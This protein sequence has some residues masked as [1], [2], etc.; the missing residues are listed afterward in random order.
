MAGVPELG[1]RAEDVGLG[2]HEHVL[3]ERIGFE[4]GAARIVFLEAQA[5][6]WRAAR[7]LFSA[8]ISAR[9][10]CDATLLED[11][12]L[13]LFERIE[14][15]EEAGGG[16]AERGGGLAGGPDIDQAV[17][18]VFALL[19]A[20]LVADGAGLGAL[21]AAEALALVADDRLDGGE[22]LGRGHQADR[23]AGAAEDR[24]DDFAVVEVGDDH[25]VLDGVAAHD[26]AGG[27]L[28]AE[29]GVAGG[30]ELVHQLFGW[31]AAVEDALVGLFQNHHAT[32]L[33]ARVVG[34]DRGGDKVGEGD[35]GD[36]AAALVHL[37]HRL[38]A[39]FP[40][41]NAHFAAQHAGVDADVGDG[42]GEREG[43][44]PGLAVFAGLRR[45]GRGSCSASTCSGVPRS[46]MG[47]RARKLA[48]LAV[49][50][51]PSTQA[52]SKAARPAPGSWGRR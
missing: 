49:A 33:D 44:A 36:E 31:G 42:L 23:D 35:V 26:A 48:R 25:A 40:L 29:D 18:R 17:Q 50:A 14:L 8:F 47:E 5:A 24:F 9:P 15:V 3:H 30:G 13:L 46:W 38:L 4:F 28:E 43:A 12:G 1:G 2:V 52:S 10:P 6:R 32:A 51:P 20:L 45:S 34:V 11:R 16:K 7:F 39:V 37:Q 22:Q 41:G 21:S 19:D 27:N